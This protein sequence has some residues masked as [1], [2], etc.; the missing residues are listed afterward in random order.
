MGRVVWVAPKKE[1]KGL[2]SGGKSWEVCL[3]SDFTGYQIWCK[4]FRS[5]R[6]ARRFMNRTFR[7][8]DTFYCATISDIGNSSF[9]VFYWNGT[10]I[11]AWDKPWI[12][13]R[14]QLLGLETRMSENLERDRG[15]QR[16][17]LDGSQ[18]GG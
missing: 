12:L 8:G 1:W 6:R 16:K 14:R 18:E 13:S 9:R 17:A 11:I 7:N 4:N 15:E 10:K 2:M 5:L 3:Y